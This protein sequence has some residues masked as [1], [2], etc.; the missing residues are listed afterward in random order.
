MMPKYLKL[1]GHYNLIKLSESVCGFVCFSLLFLIKH[2][3]MCGANGFHCYQFRADFCITKNMRNTTGRKTCFNLH[4]FL[5]N[6]QNAFPLTC[7]F[8]VQDSAITG[9]KTL[10]PIGQADNGE[11][12][13][14]PHLLC[15]ILCPQVL[16][17]FPNFLDGQ[18]E[19]SRGM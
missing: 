11:K 12:Q 17:L 19:R 9:S 1:S 3:V 14:S 6:V 18:I 7:E 10:A 8:I 13:T 16:F 5:G 2:Q 15:E 4:S